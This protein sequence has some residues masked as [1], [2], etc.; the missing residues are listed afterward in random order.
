[1]ATSANKIDAA[2][3]TLWINKFVLHKQQVF[4]KTLDIVLFISVRKALVTHTSVSMEDDVR[5][6]QES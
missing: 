6:R 5:F 4:L 3:V 2:V 1:M